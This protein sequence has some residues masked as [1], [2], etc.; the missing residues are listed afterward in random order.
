MKNGYVMVDFRGAESIEVEPFDSH[1]SLLMRMAYGKSSVEGM[2][3]AMERSA[4]APW[5]L[6]PNMRRFMPPTGFYYEPA[7]CLCN[8]ACQ[9]GTFG[10][11]SGYGYRPQTPSV[12]RGSPEESLENDEARIAKD[13]RERQRGKEGGGDL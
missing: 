1:T 8:P 5:P 11:L 10:K 13:W 6:C 3:A 4:S 9:I 2:T 7:L 12:Q